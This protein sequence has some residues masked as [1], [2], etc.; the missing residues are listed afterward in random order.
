MAR[1]QVD[2]VERLAAVDRSGLVDSERETFFDELAGMAAQLLDAPFAFVTAVD[3]ERSFWKA[4]HGI[5]DA[6]RGNAVEDS[7][8][9]YVIERRDELI[10][11]DAVV[12]PLTR[13]NPSIE[14]MGVAAWAGCPVVLDGHVL[15][16]F[17]VVDQRPRQWTD[18]DRALLHRLA[19]LANREVARRAAGGDSEP[20]LDRHQLERLRAGLVPARFPAIEGVDLAAWHHPAKGELVLGDFYSAFVL[21]DDRWC[22]VVGDVC[23]HGREAAALA[24]LIRD[25][26]GRLGA[27]HDDAASLMTACN[28]SVAERSED[29]RFATA[30]VMVLAPSADSLVV[31]TCSAGHP[32]VMVGE[33]DGSLSS[34]PAPHGPPLG[35]DPGVVYGEHRHV[36]A[37]DST[38]I[39]YT[40]GATDCRDADDML[41]GQAA[42]GR[43]VAEAAGAG[44]ASDVITHLER[45]LRRY[46]ATH[47]DDMAIVAIQ[48]RA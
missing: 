34:L 13:S 24:T 41:L 26:F 16:T 32:P 9:Q 28:R 3:D 25:E 33:P 15:G 36:M 11:D 43:Y 14:S 42:F 46:A 37:A 29:G 27:L 48:H 45:S 39:A 17:C 18:R 31:T 35:V 47:T 30:C 23:G 8:C 5:D 40:D 12:D 38:L 2:D 44:L 10:V 20:V 19:G 6:T 22:V 1:S 21:G 7:F 4:T